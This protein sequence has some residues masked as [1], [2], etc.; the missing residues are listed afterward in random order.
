MAIA[1]FPAKTVVIENELT[2]VIARSTNIF[3]TGLTAAAANT[4]PH[5]LV[6]SQG[7]AISPAEVSPTGWNSAQAAA[8]APTLDGT[9]GDAIPNS[10]AKTGWDATN[11]YVV[12]TAGVTTCVLDVFWY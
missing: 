5:G 2:G 7:V 6:S 4:I 3:V 10:T 1:V 11:V 9:Q 12:T 8:A